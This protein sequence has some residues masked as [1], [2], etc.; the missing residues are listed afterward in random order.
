MMKKRL[1]ITVMLAAVLLASCGQDDAKTKDANNTNATE[2]TEQTSNVAS[3]NKVNSKLQEPK[4][5]TV[6][7]FCNMKVY[8]A[9]HE[10]GAFSAQAINEDGS[11]IFFDDAGCMLNQERKDKVKYDKYVRDYNSKEWLKLDDAIIVKADIKTPM[12]YGYA[13]F[14]DQES[15]DAFI[16]E[17][18][19]AKVVEVSDID[20]VAHERYK[21]KMQKMK[22]ND[23]S[24]KMDMN[25]NN[26]DSEGHEK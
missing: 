19:G 9:D 2:K 22:N 23:S 24:D 4:E 16:K 14:K 10:M 3:L 20:D 13:F 7:E 12:N 11:T 5:D 1:G 21:K 6:C 15:A 18:T 8:D 17:N 26:D 25:M